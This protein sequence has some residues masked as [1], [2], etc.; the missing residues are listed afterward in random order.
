M[1]KHIEP[2]RTRNSITRGCKTCIRTMLHQSDLNKWRLTKLVK[3]SK[4]YIN[5]ASTRILQ[6]S[7]IDDI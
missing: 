2:T 4:L 6:R 3:L 1:P 5:A 7:K